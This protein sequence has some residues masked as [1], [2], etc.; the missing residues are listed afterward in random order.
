MAKIVQVA[1]VEKRYPSDRR[2]WRSK[3][4]AKVLVPSGK[5]GNIDWVLR[6]L[7]LSRRAL[8]RVSVSFR[9]LTDGEKKKQQKINQQQRINH[10]RDTNPVPM[11]G[12][13]IC[14][15]C[16]GPIHGNRKICP[17]CGQDPLIE[18]GDMLW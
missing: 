13:I 1:V 10:K 8:G 17:I 14:N 9:Q 16:G 2:P 3:K 15:A 4:P 7:G 11:Q 6:Q 18:L 12:Y 5:R